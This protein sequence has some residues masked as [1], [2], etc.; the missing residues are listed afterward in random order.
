MLPV[1]SESAAR[2]LPPPASEALEFEFELAAHRLHAYAGAAQCAAYH[3]TPTS[4]PSFSQSTR[5]YDI[6]VKFHSTV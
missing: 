1:A 3:L 2:A 5:V 4:N 6:N